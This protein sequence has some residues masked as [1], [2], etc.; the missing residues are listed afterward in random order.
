MLRKLNSLV[1]DL[2]FVTGVAYVVYPFRKFL[3]FLSNLSELTRWI[4]L[5]KNKVRNKDFFVWKRDY[6]RRL[7]GFNYIINEFNLENEPVIYL[8]FGVASGA[9][10][11][12][13]LNHLK[14]TDTKF[15]GFDTFEGLPENWGL[16]YKKG[17]MA[18]ELKE[19]SDNRHQFIKGIFQDTLNNFI[20]AKR[21][22]LF[23]EKRKVIH[24][25][26]DLFTATLFVLTQ[27]Y[28]YMRKGDLIIFDEF[29]V[30][31][32]EF[33][34]LKLFQECFYIK[35]QPVSALNNFYQTIFIVEK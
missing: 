16:F 6:N 24:M 35:L 5:N 10:F 13:W 17:A 23:S 33:Y 22:I 31:N 9:S 34:A 1:K 27:L 3:L 26:A 12:W 2:V 11:E 21:D 15:F 8:E 29:N 18:H 19:I 32:H 7:D 4:H 28:P 30:P 25:D 14:N 20:E